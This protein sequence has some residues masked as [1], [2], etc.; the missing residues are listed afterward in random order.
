MPQSSGFLGGGGSTG[1]GSSGG[2]ATPS[3]LE[4]RLAAVESGKED[5]STVAAL[6]AR[7][8]AAEG[9]KEEKAVVAAINTRVT[10]LEAAAGPGSV[11]E[12]NRLDNRPIMFCGPWYDSYWSPINP[13]LD[14]MKLNGVRPDPLLF[15]NQDG[16]GASVAAAI[17]ADAIDPTTLNPR[18]GSVGPAPAPFGRVCL[19]PV[20]FNGRYFPQRFSGRWV[21]TWDGVGTPEV[22][23]APLP[24]VSTANRREFDLDFGNAVNE[25]ATAMRIEFVLCG[26][27]FGNVKFYRLADEARVMAGEIYATPFLQGVSR[28]KG[29]RPMDWNEQGEPWFKAAQRSRMTTG[30]WG[31]TDAG[32]LNRHRFANPALPRTYSI[33]GVP[34]EAQ[35]ELAIRANVALWLNVSPF[36]G[37]QAGAYAYWNPDN[38]YDDR[39]ALG[40]PAVTAQATQQVASLEWDNYA[41]AIVSTLNEKQYPRK[42]MLYVEVGNEIWNTALP[43][44]NGTW[45]YDRLGEGLFPGGG[46]AQHRRVLGWMSARFAEAMSA[47][48]ARAGRSDQRWTI[49]VAG[50]NKRPD[51][52]TRVA[53]EGF[54]DYFL[55]KS[56]ATAPWFAKVG[57]STSSYFENA[58]EQGGA[59]AAYDA[60]PTEDARRAA[61]LAEI[62]A[63]PVAAATK[64]A[65]WFIT[66]LAADKLTIPNM[67]TFKQ[68]HAAIAAEFGAAY[69]GDYEGGDHEWG[70]KFWGA[71]WSNSAGYRDF[72][73][74]FRYGAQ[75]NRVTA[76]WINQTKTAFPDGI[77]SNYAAPGGYFNALRAYRTDSWHDGAYGVVTGRETALNDN[78]R[79]AA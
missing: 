69:I 47:A 46:A 60:Q 3:A 36:L 49:V 51:A 30:R 24:A 48:L 5:K 2:G 33:Y 79:P 10:A 14:E 65:T 52:S 75:G 39:F 67:V 62:E 4:T 38:S 6:A 58:F 71:T 19:G 73:D 22:A 61:I 25:G 15:Y 27:G 77:V 17:A 26:A 18:P 72:L 29:V 28:Y 78:L 34:L 8:T 57:V 54:R 31:D 12:P 68:G 7:V 43:F 21:L 41:D 9:A 70:G 1:G 37:M 56:T 20:A 11:N 50:Q 35:V 64:V 66:S 42:R 44:F 53:L 45:A 23:G 16:T 55:A 40:G 76:A 63:G 13:Y 74:E 59:F 32:D